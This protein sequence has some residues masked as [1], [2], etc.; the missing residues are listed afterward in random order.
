MAY[1]TVRRFLLVLQATNPK[2]FDIA[3]SNL[4]EV[5]QTRSAY[6]QVRVEPPLP[7]HRMPS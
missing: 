3:V 5:T 7:A 4:I 2:A 1:L 6:G